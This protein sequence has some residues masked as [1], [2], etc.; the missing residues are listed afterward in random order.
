MSS[1]Q[2]LPIVQTPAPDD[3]L[4]MGKG[5]EFDSTK[6]LVSAFA[7]LAG[8]TLGG[9]LAISETP[10]SGSEMLW[11]RKDG[12]GTILDFWVKQEDEWRS[13]SKQN[14]TRYLADYVSRTYD[15]YV[16]LE[17]AGVTNKIHVFDTLITATGARNDNDTLIVDLE[18]YSP[19]GEPEVLATESFNGFVAGE[20]YR[21]TVAINKTLKL[22]QRL[23]FRVR[24]N[25][26][27][28]RLAGV[29]VAASFQLVY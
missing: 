14:E 23:R 9:Q 2:T 16:G 19:T 28:I 8:K 11:F 24:P 15:S 12:L 10:P 22:D 21:R 17:M 18:A 5:T 29:S 20:E 26:G 25:R 1:F 7:A 3:Y 6:M 4:L 13:L 27:T